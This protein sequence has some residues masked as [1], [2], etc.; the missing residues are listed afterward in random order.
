M[1]VHIFTLGG[2][3]PIIY[4]VY[5]ILCIRSLHLESKRKDP[6]KMANLLVIG[7]FPNLVGGRKIE[8]NQPIPFG[9]ISVDFKEFPN[10]FEDHYYFDLLKEIHELGGL[11]KFKVGKDWAEYQMVGDARGGDFFDTEITKI[12]SE[13]M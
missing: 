12:F 6:K 2:C 7:R 3:G 10:G 1:G 5:I 11:L 9:D 8:F 13:Y 4:V